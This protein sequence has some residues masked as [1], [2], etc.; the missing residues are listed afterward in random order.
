M[1]L[2]CDSGGRKGR[3]SVGVELVQSEEM[4]EEDDLE[5]CYSA[6]EGCDGSVG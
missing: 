3:D 4:P 1:V 5:L 2:V 6:I